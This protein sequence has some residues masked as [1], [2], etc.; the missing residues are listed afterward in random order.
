[1]MNKNLTNIMNDAELAA[2]NGGVT[3]TSTSAKYKVGDIVEVFF[4][5]YS[6]WTNRG[7]VRDVELDA[8]G[9][10][11]YIGFEDWFMPNHWVREDSIAE[12]VR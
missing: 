8:Q 4:P 2:I 10:K 9:W 1:M 6:G 12:R 3:N 7:E 11:Y 5:L